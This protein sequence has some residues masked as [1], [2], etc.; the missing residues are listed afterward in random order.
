MGRAGDGWEVAGRACGRLTSS[1]STSSAASARFS[2]TCNRRMSACTATVRPRTTRRGGVVARSGAL[3][4]APDG[5][6][7]GSPRLERVYASPGRTERV[8]CHAAARNL[9]RHVVH[10]GR[11]LRRAALKVVIKPAVNRRRPSHPA[12]P[13][14]ACRGLATAV[15]GCVALPGR[16]RAFS[17]RRTWTRTSSSP[18]SASPAGRGRS[19]SG[20]ARILCTHTPCAPQTFVPRILQSGCQLPRT[21]GRGGAERAGG[22]AETGTRVPAG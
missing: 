10:R 6:H 7:Q 5:E 13:H 19:Q 3:A 22:E 16:A 20:P 9:L 17:L 8:L 21:K 2:R 18:P 15:R 11:E 4:A 1:I 12:C 14:R